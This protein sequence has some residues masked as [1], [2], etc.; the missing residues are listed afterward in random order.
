MKIEKFIALNIGFIIQIYYF[1]EMLKKEI[2]FFEL[3]KTNSNIDN[4]ILLLL[5]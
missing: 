1:M 3:T 2:I 4:L 5:I